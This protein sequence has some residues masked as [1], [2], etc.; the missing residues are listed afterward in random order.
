MGAAK[1]RPDEVGV[2]E[3]ARERI[4]RAAAHL[5]ALRGYEGTS[6]R[7]IAEAA[8]VTKPLI[9]Y[10]FASKE[11]LFSNLLREAIDRCR[12]AG[13]EIL[14]Q[15]APAKEKL[16]GLLR[17]HV[18]R[19]REQPEIFAFAYE[20]LTMPG[21]LPLGFDY[22]TE[23]QQLFRDL[24]RLIEEGQR[25]GEFRKIDPILVAVV[26]LSAL[27]MFVSAVLAGDLDKIPEGLEETLLDLIL[28]GLEVRG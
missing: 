1:R 7:E 21:L 12:A 13:K 6:M 24:A 2:Q 15:D 9:F 20:V 4:L 16:R 19:A 17:G 11:R 3:G 25:R 10:H 18:A 28:H 8:A 27:G 5:Y 23:G 22:K 14:E 26:P